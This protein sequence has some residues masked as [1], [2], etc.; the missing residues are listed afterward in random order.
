MKRMSVRWLM[1]IGHG[2]GMM[3]ILLALAGLRAAGWISLSSRDLVIVAVLSAGVAGGLNLLI[4]FRWLAPALRALHQLVRTPVSEPEPP[5]A[6]HASGGVEW[7][8]L[9]RALRDQH[10]TMHAL[11]AMGR[12]Y[13]DSGRLPVQEGQV[14]HDLGA[15]T[16]QALR[17]LRGMDESVGRVARG[18]LYDEI[19]D[20]LRETPF[21]R[22]LHDMT[23]VLRTMVADVRKETRQLSAASAQV[24]AMSQAGSRTATT[25]TEEIDTISSAIHEVAGNLREVMQ[26]IRRQADSLDQTF[27]D[28]QDLL[29]STEHVSTNVELLAASSEA[30]SR[31][32]H[33]I[34]EFMQ[35]IDRHAHSLADISDTVS[36][37]AT[38]GG[39]AV[40][41]VI[42][43]IHTI[44]STVQAAAGAIRRLG[45]E[46]GRIGEILE[47]INGVAEQTN[48]L[49]LNASIIAAQAGEHGRGFSVVADEIK[50]LAE[51]TRASTQEI[52]GIIHGLQ[53]EVGEG[54]QA[55]DRCLEAVAD[56]VVL[57]NQAGDILDTIVQ[58]I[59][60]AREMAASLA[61]ATVTQT[62]N[63]EQVNHATEQVTQKIDEL[64]A[65]AMQQARDSTHLAE[66]ANVLKD[67][68]QQIETSAK[69]QSQATD[70]IA[71]SIEEIQMLVQRNADLAHSLAAS[72]EELGALES[73]LAQNMGHFLITLPH[74][75][76]DF[77]A[78]Q[79]G[80]V[81]LFPEA[82]FFYQHIYHGLA[83]VLAGQQYQTLALDSQNDP[84]LQAEYL[85]W[86]LRQP[87]VQGLFLCS[88]DEQTGGCVARD[89]R[90]AGMP[91]IVVDRP[92]SDAMVSVFS[93]NQQ[94]GKSA[95]ELLHERLP[96][97]ATVM[98]CG[99][100]N[101]T[102][103]F[104][105]MEG[106]FQQ[107]RSY[108]W[109]VVEAFTSVMNIEEAKQSMLQ[110]I[111]RTPDVQGMFLANEHASLAYLELLKEG[112]L[113]RREITAVSYDINAS[114]VEALKTGDLVGSIFQ[115]PPQLGRTAAR[116]MLD[117]LKGARKMA[118]GTAPQE[119]FTPVKKVTPQNVTEFWPLPEE[120]IMHIS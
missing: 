42:E 48:L 101:I 82:P 45:Q 68:T 89:A 32:I 20:I 76:A 105:R 34:H 40:G 15:L 71:A 44:E 2:V 120:R 1:V 87:W 84:I 70:A 69:T 12:E 26:N 52:G 24:A 106:F 29:A 114:I 62:R 33:E 27:A 107:S 30:T 83:E 95:A 22:A 86:A 96:S 7:R 37:E 38:E 72:S 39:S 36:S 10:R 31:S 61:E 25:A 119:V 116:Y 97:D 11:V 60:G 102:S 118:P 28:I 9:E 66:M 35:E 92:A 47:V 74:L 23:Q 14:S 99:P 109:R 41:T 21:G 17:M 75:P 19:P 100:R 16:L 94:G 80:F 73:R 64:H 6:P 4:W 3:S 81:F 85:T 104:T 5:P 57:A 46:S 113:S 91:L 90:A 108:G 111:Q 65:T 54:T 59:Q 43:G 110:S 18:E 79:P 88:L 58:N 13:L 103:M 56:G 98:A 8:E 77:D 93:D 51:R 115:D 78:A 117:L 55:I 53:H 50:E 112:R 67:V 49:A 63:S